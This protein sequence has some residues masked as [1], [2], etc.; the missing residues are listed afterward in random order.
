MV[1]YT[2]GTNNNAQSQCVPDIFYGIIYNVVGRV[3]MP[4]QR[5]SSAVFVY[6]GI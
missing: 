6:Q 4:M 1:T 3:Y 2:I 5:C